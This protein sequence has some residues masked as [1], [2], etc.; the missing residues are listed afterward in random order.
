[1]STESPSVLDVSEQD[2]QQEVLDRSRT[3][4]VVVDFWA[5][6]CGPCRTLG[7]ILERLAGQHAGEFQ[8]VKLN[9]DENPRLAAQFRIQGIPAVKAF[10][11]GRVVDEFVGALPE[12]QVKAWLAGILPTAADRLAKEGSELAGAG[13][14][15]A[16]E[17]RFRQALAI[18]VNH[19]AA[20][21][22]LARILV[23]RGETEEAKQLLR[24]MPADPEIAKLLAQLELQANGAADIDALRTQAEANPKDPAAAYELGAAL[25]AAGD[26]GAA[27]EALLASVRLDRHFEEDAARKAMLHIFQLLGDDHPLTGEYRRRLSSVLF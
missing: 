18:D 17:D 14:A 4:P 2:F 16:A 3:I 22:G 27:L 8:L 9:T 6:W 21:A 10:R 7:P 24:R 15:N 19:P 20:I 12:Q 1:M 5:P 13:Y 11:D 23:A 25:A 26:H